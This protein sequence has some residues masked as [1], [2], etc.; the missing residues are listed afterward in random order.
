LGDLEVVLS[1]FRLVYNE[2]LAIESFLA[3]IHHSFVSFVFVN[4]RDWPL[5]SVVVHAK[6]RV[7]CLTEQAFSALS[8]RVSK[9]GIK[10]DP[11]SFLRRGFF[12]F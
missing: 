9:I 5:A 1:P 6:K 11:R 2:S 7:R 4:N 10:A 12:C 3:I 8:A